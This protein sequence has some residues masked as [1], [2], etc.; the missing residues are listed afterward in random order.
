MGFDLMRAAYGV[1]KPEPPR[2]FNVFARAMRSA[3]PGI[4]FARAAAA[5]ETDLLTDPDSRL[6]VGMKPY[7]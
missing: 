6:F 5:G 1:N 7:R 3:S 2:G 4:V